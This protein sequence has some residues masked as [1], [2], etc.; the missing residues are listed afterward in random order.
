[1]AVSIGQTSQE[2][3]CECCSTCFSYFFLESKTRLHFWQYTL[4]TLFLENSSMF[5]SVT[6]AYKDPVENHNMEEIPNKILVGFFVVILGFFWYCTTRYYVRP[7]CYK[8]VIY[9]VFGKQV[10]SD[11]IRTDFKMY[12]VAQ[13][14]ILEYQKRF[15]NH[16]FSISTQIPHTRRTIFRRFVRNHK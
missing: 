12:Q 10:S 8:I 13:S 11:E 7:D 14:H 3:L 16:S 1:M 4:L 2:M 5:F 9:D 15:P 6:S